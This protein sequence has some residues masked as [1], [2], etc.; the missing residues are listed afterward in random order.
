MSSK[1][2]TEQILGRLRENEKNSIYVDINDNGFPKTK[3]Q[4]YSRMQVFNKFAKKIYELD[5]D[6]K[7]RKKIIG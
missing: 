3:N 1:V 2:L 6:I 7:K 4:R 5:Y